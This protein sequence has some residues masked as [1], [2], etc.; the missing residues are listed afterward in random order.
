MAAAAHSLVA[1]DEPVHV[2]TESRAGRSALVCDPAVEF[3][4]M[5]TLCQVVLTLLFDEETDA[6]LMIVTV[7][8]A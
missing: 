7:I 2:S 8:P 5:R 4:G 3:L 6:P 1:K